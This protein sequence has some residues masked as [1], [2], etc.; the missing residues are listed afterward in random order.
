MAFAVNHWNHNNALLVTDVGSTKT[1]LCRAIDDPRFIGSHPIA[2]S[3]QSGPGAANAD[4]FLN[5]AVVLTPTACHSTSDIDRFSQFWTA[6]G[7]HVSITTPERHDEML[8]VTSHLPHLL[9]AVLASTLRQE[10]R[11]FTG[12]GYSDMTR[13]SAGHPALWRDILLDNS[14]NVLAAIKRFEKS[15]SNMSALLKSKDADGME[16][17]LKQSQ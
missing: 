8:A 13:L 9:S 10:E 11:P 3:E 1:S 15:L 16:E 6:L 17:Y 14:E 7:S 5:R 4:L 2:G 12:T